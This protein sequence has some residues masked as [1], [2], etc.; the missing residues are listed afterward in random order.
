MLKS[1]YRKKEREKCNTGNDEE[2][3]RER[4]SQD[5]YVRILSAFPERDSAKI[6]SNIKVACRFI[7]SLA[8]QIVLAR[9]YGREKPA[10]MRSR[11]NLI[12]AALY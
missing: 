10:S 9:Y 11:V 2:R 6:S 5:F 4:F 1:R 8:T 12:H 3:E 7:S